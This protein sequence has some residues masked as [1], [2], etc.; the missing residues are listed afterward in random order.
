MVD[1]C[2]ICM[3]VMTSTAVLYCST[4]EICQYTYV[5][6]YAFLKY[7]Y[8]DSVDNITVEDTVGECL[9]PVQMVAGL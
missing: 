6:Y 1:D 5:V 8:T 7:L 3:A 9:V 2:I 4:I